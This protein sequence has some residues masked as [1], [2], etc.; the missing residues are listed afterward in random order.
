MPV[1]LLSKM[2]LGYFTD[3]LLSR[4]TEGLSQELKPKLLYTHVDVPLSLPQV[5]NV[6]ISFTNML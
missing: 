6:W 2:S 5:H 4:A 3:F 1:L